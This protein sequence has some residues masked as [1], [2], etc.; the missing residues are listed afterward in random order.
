MTCAKDGECRD[1]ADGAKRAGV[2]SL[3]NNVRSELN[4]QQ[5]ESEQVRARI[6]KDEEEKL[7]EELIEEEARITFL[8]TGTGAGTGAG[9]P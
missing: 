2:N 3:I 1:A 6:L 5:K 8:W 7:K 4:T 9:W